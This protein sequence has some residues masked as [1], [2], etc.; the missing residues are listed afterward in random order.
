LH[1]SLT[2]LTLITFIEEDLIY[3]CGKYNSTDVH[4]VL[5]RQVK[6]ATVNVAS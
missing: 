3:L 2:W 6:S 4:A 1:G 5:R